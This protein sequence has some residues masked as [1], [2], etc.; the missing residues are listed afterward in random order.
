MASTVYLHIGLPKT[1][2][3][4]LQSV[5]WGARD[6]LARDGYLLPGSG[7]REHLWAALDLQERRN[8]ARRHPDAPGT[9]ERLLAEVERHRGPAIITHEFFCGARR[10]QVDRLL[11]RLAPAQVHVVV[12][13]RDA[14][15][16]LTAGWAEYVKNG[17]TTPLSEMG[18]E[19]TD[20]Q[21]EFGWRTWD[22]A[23]VLRRWGRQLPPEQ[24]H[25]VPMPGR[26][27]PRDQHW[28]NVA[29]VLGLDPARYDAPEEARNPALGVTQVELLRRINPHLTGE[30]GGFRRPVDRGTWIR[31]YL[32]ERHLVGQGGE[33]LGAGPEQVA[34]CRERAEKAVA[35]IRRRGFHVQGEVES[36]LV[37]HDLPVR[38]RPHDVSDAE[39]LGS[40]S[41]LVAGLL[42]DVRRLS[43]DAPDL[44]EGA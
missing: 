7:H 28:R 8:L 29:T 37:P 2:T 4:Y 18:G 43:R 21:A 16:M 38:Q 44:I 23:G 27:A 36:L 12:T 30:G 24:V 5:L 39:L 33:R 31:G 40:A 9:L 10:A 41:M 42:E 1:G 22:L 34:E 11:E 6:Q 26:G 35:M 14:L 32:A 3:T 20:G 17:G 13:A 25:V 19:A 15:G